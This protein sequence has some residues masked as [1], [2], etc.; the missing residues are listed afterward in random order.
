MRVV[1]GTPQFVVVAAI[2]SVVW[3]VKRTW[4]AVA[5]GEMPEEPWYRPSHMTA[6]VERI[7]GS[8]GE[9]LHFWEVY[10]DDL[11][12]RTDAMREAGIHLLVFRVEPA[13]HVGR[14][15]VEVRS[16]RGADDVRIGYATFDRNDV[17]NH[18]NVFE[19]V[20]DEEGKS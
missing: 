16:D 3:F 2:Q 4:D 5:A 6:Q 13:F 11:V 10:V 14:F 20:F 15:T 12:Y 18:A 19:T 9:L 7:L 8:F 1:R 17:L